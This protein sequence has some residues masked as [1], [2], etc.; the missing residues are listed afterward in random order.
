[1]IVHERAVSGADDLKAFA[2]LLGGRRA[3]LQRE[4]VHEVELD[5]DVIV[6]VARD[7]AGV[8]AKA[9]EEPAISASCAALP[10]ICGTA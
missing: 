6:D 4:H 5:A 3:F 2:L 8:I 10:L 1:M 7:G 9:S